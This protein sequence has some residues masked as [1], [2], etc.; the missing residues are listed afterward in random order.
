ME[1]ALLRSISG[2]GKTTD[3]EAK[4]AFMAILGDDTMAEL[5]SRYDS[6][7]NTIDFLRT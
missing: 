6:H 2:D 5:A 7:P 3:F 1:S 4:V